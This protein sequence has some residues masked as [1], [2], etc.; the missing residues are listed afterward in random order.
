MERRAD[1]GLRTGH[2]SGCPREN[3]PPR[4]LTDYA[5][6]EDQFGVFASRG[7]LLAVLA[8][9]GRARQGERALRDGPESRELLDKG[10]LRCIL[11]LGWFCF[12]D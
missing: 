5:E 8:R 3:L 1:D 6:G 2:A 10:I 7:A 4:R 9:T 11:N 12:H